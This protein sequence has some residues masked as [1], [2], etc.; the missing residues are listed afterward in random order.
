MPYMLLLVP[1][2]SFIL[3][4]LHFFRNSFYLA[5]AL[6]LVLP[7]LLAVRRLWAARLVQVC[8]CLGA[9]EWLRT[10]QVLVA[11]R[12]QAGGPATRLAVI[13]G[14]VAFATVLSAVVFQTS[15][16]KNWF[17]PGRERIDT[18]HEVGVEKNNN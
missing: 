2:F 8:L 15:R 4:A 12:I 11:L 1:I 6:C 16:V 17:N 9:I 7:C 5:A 13:L 3:L 18:A 14:C 10:M